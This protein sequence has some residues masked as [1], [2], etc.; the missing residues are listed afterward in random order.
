MLTY[1]TAR[2]EDVE[3]LFALEKG[4]IDAYEDRESI[5]YEKVLGWVE[6]KLEK[7]VGEF[8]RV[9]RD[10]ELV[11]YYHL[12]PSGEKW[13]LD[14]L[15]V[16]PGY[17]GQGIGTAVLERCFAQAEGPIFLYVFVRNTGAVRLYER[18][19]FRVTERVGKTRYIME[20]EEKR[21]GTV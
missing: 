5:D 20:R 8:T 2:A 14:D 12:T 17:Q 11:G 7:Q 10:G 15:F 6:R 18:M 16:L 21:H 9:L 3:R 4:L 13:E 19:G 1:E